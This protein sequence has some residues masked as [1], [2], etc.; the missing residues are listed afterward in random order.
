MGASANRHSEPL[1][2]AVAGSPL[3]AR[4]NKDCS[5]VFKNAAECQSTIYP[6]RALGFGSK[7]DLMRANDTGPLT[8]DAHEV[9]QN[10]STAAGFRG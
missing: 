1:P 3:Q 8:K 10:E 7:P 5:T 9:Q 2:G 4:P 6:L